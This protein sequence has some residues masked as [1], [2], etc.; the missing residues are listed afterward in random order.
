MGG[1]RASHLARAQ[2][3]KQ[4]GWAEDLGLCSRA[5]GSQAGFFKQAPR[6]AGTLKVI[7]RCV[8]WNSASKSSWMV[9]AGTPEAE[10]RGQGLEATWWAALGS[11]LHTLPAASPF[12]DCHQAARRCG[13]KLVTTFWM[14]WLFG[15]SL[16]EKGRRESHR[17]HFFSSWV[18][19]RVRV[20]VS[21]AAS[22][23]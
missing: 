15:L 6:H 13:A 20:N 19:V 2:R 9:T 8:K 16:A 10:V 21:A 3:M 5:L 11:S 14:R 22:P 17:K 7:M 12:S 23:S 18:R 1:E 4:R